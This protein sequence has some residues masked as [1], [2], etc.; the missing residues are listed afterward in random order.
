MNKELTVGVGEYVAESYKAY[1]AYINEHR[2]IPS[3]YDGLKPSYRRVMYTSIKNS[4]KKQKTNTLLGEVMKLHSHGEDSIKNVITQL[5]NRKIFARM[6]N[7]GYFAMYG[8]SMPAA[9]PRYTH[10]KINDNW[11]EFFRDLMDTVPYKVSDADSQFKEPEYL[12]SAIPL[13][14]TMGGSGI[15]LGISTEYPAFCPRSILEAY[16]ADDPQLLKPA[17]DIDLDYENSDLDG[18]W[19]TGYG[20]IIWK[21]KITKGYN[22]ATDGV[23]VE[24]DTSLFTP[25]WDQI[26]IWRD[27]G[28]VHVID[29]SRG[30]KGKVFVGRNKNIRAVNQDMI[31][32]ELKRC[33]T[34]LTATAAH[35]QVMRLAVH[36]GVRARYL[37]MKEWVN[38]TYTNYERLLE[39]YRSEK[40]RNLEFSKSVY[41]N[42][43]SVAKLIFDDPDIT[44]ESII[45]TLSL[46]EEIVKAI[47]RKSINTLRNCDTDSEISKIEDG[48]AYYTNII[49]KDRIKELIYAL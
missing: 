17:Y 3:I 27:Q 23:Y 11:Y 30:D 22:G 2:A 41:N 31:Y 5:V 16:L 42:L 20:R 9:H 40:I 12:P 24:G 38:F 19:N 37:S 36:D 47:L 49:I 28:R 21:Y 46:N 44:V 43:R 15:G 35:K 1:G 33:T 18:I 25:V 6:G 14:L 45:E 48:I 39:N 32:E 8:Q 29:E 34:S 10:T 26:N 7:F 13:C 4:G